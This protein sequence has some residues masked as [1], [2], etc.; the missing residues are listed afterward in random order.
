MFMAAV[1]TVSI[2]ALKM[3]PQKHGAAV[4]A[5]SEAADRS[6]RKSLT[7]S[8]VAILHRWT[9]CSVGALLHPALT[10]RLHCWKTAV[11]TLRPFTAA[12]SRRAGCVM[13]VPASAPGA[14]DCLQ[15]GRKRNYTHG[16]HVL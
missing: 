1:C 12:V 10:R 7:A 11:L 16:C 2:S 8:W 14:A 9:D 15:D 3:V 4:G 13:S 6:T 5:C